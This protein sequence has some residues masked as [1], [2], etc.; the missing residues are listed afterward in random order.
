M[1]GLYF[2]NKENQTASITRYIS[3]YKEVIY[4]ANYGY[5]KCCSF[6]SIEDAKNFLFKMGY[7][8]Q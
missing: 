5:Y 4:F 2:V 6:E 7:K 3:K 1:E 8:P